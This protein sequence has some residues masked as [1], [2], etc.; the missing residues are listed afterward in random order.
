MEIWR[1]QPE[2]IGI[3]PRHKM[4]GTADHCIS[5]GKHGILHE[6]TPTQIESLFVLDGMRIATESVML[7]YHS[8][9]H[10]KKMTF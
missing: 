9:F 4:A 6:T 10:G 5:A 7:S 3:V 1:K 2:S 8:N